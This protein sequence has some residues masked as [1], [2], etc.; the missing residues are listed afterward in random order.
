[1]RKNIEAFHEL[2]RRVTDG[3]VCSGGEDC[4]DEFPFCCHYDG[5]GNC[6][7]CIGKDIELLIQ[8][9]IKFRCHVDD[10]FYRDEVCE[11]DFE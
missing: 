1:M 6:E 2:V 5:K 9:L 4:N 3:V 8:L 11:I 7:E 10:P